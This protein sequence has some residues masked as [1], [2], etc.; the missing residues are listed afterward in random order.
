MKPSRTLFTITTLALALLVTIAIPSAH[1]GKK[2]AKEAEKP[3]VDPRILIDSVDASAGTVV[4]N[5]KRDG[6][7]HTYTLDGMS[8]IKVGDSTDPAKISDIKTGMQVRDYVE[9]DD[10][11][12]DSITVSTADPAPAK[13]KKEGATTSTDTSSDPTDSSN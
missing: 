13:A 10:H 5:Y 2:K 4:L 6:T 7:T 11:T 12:L 8:T 9:R 3:V 1:A